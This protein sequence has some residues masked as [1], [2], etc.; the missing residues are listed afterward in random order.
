V[1]LLTPPFAGF[2]ADPG[3]IGYWPLGNRPSTTSNFSLVPSAVT[4]NLRSAGAALPTAVHSLF[5][6]TPSGVS[7]AWQNVVGTL[8]FTSSMPWVEGAHV[9]SNWSIAFWYEAGSSA[10]QH[11]VARE[12]IH[13]PPTKAEQLN[14]RLWWTNADETWNLQV[15]R[16]DVA[17]TTIKKP[18]PRRGMIAVTSSFEPNSAGTIVRKV[19]WYH[20]GEFYGDES[21]TAPDQQFGT[22]SSARFQVMNSSVAGQNYT[23]VSTSFGWSGT[24][25][26]VGVWPEALSAAKIRSLYGQ[27]VQTYDAADLWDAGAQLTRYRVYLLDDDARWV[28][29]TDLEGVDYVRSLSV[30][31]R[32]GEDDTI[33]LRL[34]RFRGTYANLSPLGEVAG[35]P[36]VGLVGLRRRVLVTRAITPPLMPPKPSDFRYLASG[37]IESWST[38]QDSIDV[39]VV[40]DGA[41][42]R[43]NFIVDPRGYVFNPVNKAAEEHQQQIIDDNEPA[44]KSAAAT[45]KIGYKGGRPVLYSLAGSFFTPTFR[46]TGQTLR[47]NDVGTGHTAAAI[48][49]VSDQ[50]G[51]DTR[52]MARDDIQDSRLLSY[53]PRRQKTLPYRTL[54][55]ASGNAFVD[56]TTDEPHNLALGSAVSLGGTAS[57]N[58]LGT[59]ASVNNWFNFRVA[60]SSGYSP[61]S[62]AVLSNGTLAFSYSLALRAT[63]LYGVDPITAEA[64][65]IRNHTV[66]RYQRNESTTTV[67]GTVTRTGGKAVF[68]ADETLPLIDPENN[69]I[70]FTLND[71][72]DAGMQQF[73]ANYTGFLTGNRTATSN[74]TVPTLPNGSATSVIF[75]SQNQVYREVVST[76][77]ASVREY[78]F[79]PAA[80]FEG[81]S[82][83]INTFAEATA[84][85]DAVTSDLS[86][87][88]NDFR[89]TTRPNHLE[90]HDVIRLPQDPKQR[91]SG[92]YD[93]AVVGITETA[94]S[95]QCRAVLDIR[96]AKPSLGPGWASRVVSTWEKPTLV[97]NYKP[98]L[99]HLTARNRIR[100][101]QAG[102]FVSRN[103]AGRREMGLRH[104]KTVVWMSTASG[105]I[106][107]EANRVAEFRGEHISLRLD[108][109]GNRLTPGTTY[110][111]RFADRDIFGNL[112]EIQGLNTATAASTFSVTPRYTEVS[113]AAFAIPTTAPASTTIDSTTLTVVSDGVVNG[114]DAA[115]LSFDVYGNR[116]AFSPYFQC[117]APGMYAIAH[118]ST[119]FGDHTK[120]PNP[121][122]AWF[123]NA[124][125]LRISGGGA[126]VATAQ[127]SLAT[128]RFAG[129]STGSLRFLDLSANVSCASGD[130]LAV[131]AGAGNDCLRAP[132]PSSTTNAFNYTRFTL[133]HQDP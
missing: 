15:P 1:K 110:F 105:F 6:P 121:T 60:V 21:D 2:L 24:M 16:S 28:D 39:R 49:A 101:G 111:L 67:F 104:D 31:K 71:A 107:T 128:F 100:A 41:P 70:T 86:E 26:E 75:T 51:A 95:G 58:F 8:W 5:D 53:S 32:V 129:P 52:Y 120:V 72:S 97:G 59:V 76:A 29:L 117:P 109:D 94:E 35:A 12:T 88:P 127:F 82:L 38:E 125:I 68:V 118:R 44:L 124:R 43:D 17:T 119:Y 96:Y 62:A 83:G 13:S 47:F 20:N 131:V 56:V 4:G 18:M 11:A 112:S 45:V 66:V 92:T 14:F 30:Q 106:P 132:P 23:L 50:I 54:A 40:D 57:H 73:E 9:H 85:A 114:S 7:K 61:T 46:R 55:P 113:A 79:M 48:Q 84:L 122:D 108:G 126:S 91:W 3:Q 74:E 102:I 89:L 130:R 116:T 115:A 42:L 98:P 65:A 27:C 77:T 90:L 87:P 93:G 99:S 25:Q 103:A 22:S 81:S 123:V 10:T 63:D 69:G 34:L 33:S 37:R 19:R 64:S 36:Y 80:I 133:I 78:G